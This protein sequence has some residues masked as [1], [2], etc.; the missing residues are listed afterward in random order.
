MKVGRNKPC[1]CGSGLKYKKCCNGQ[2]KPSPMGSNFW[3]H[4]ETLR[5]Q[6]SARERIRQSQ[7]GLGR[8]IVAAEVQGRRI[9]AVRNKLHFSEKWK[10][11]PDFLLAYLRESLGR[12]WG[13]T[14]NSKESDR[15]HPIITWLAE[16]SAFQKSQQKVEGTG[17]YEAKLN[18]LAV[19]LFGLAYNLY[20]LDHNADLQARLLSRLR[21]T[22]QFQGAYYELLI[23]GALIRAGFELALEDEADRSTKHCEF[24][25]RSK[26]SKQHYSV[27]VKMKAM[28]GVLGI[29][30]QGSKDPKPHSSLVKQLNQSFKKPSQSTRLIFI[31][32][33]TPLKLDGMGLPAWKNDVSARIDKYENA[34]LPDGE[35]A[36]L[37]V[38]NLPFH[39]HLFDAPSMAVL[40]V[41]LGIS[42]FNR[43]GSRRFTDE[44]LLRKKHAD[45]YAICESIAKAYV[46]PTTFDGSLPS[47]ALGRSRGRV[48]IGNT[49]D[50]DGIVGTVT[51]AT[52]SEAEK[53]TY[54]A[55]QEK[56][57]KSSIL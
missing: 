38:T 53:V 9:V 52:V 55:V 51:S 43:P 42:D 34:E 10:T 32:L 22:D 41:G 30:E 4:L 54:V 36:Y 37:F 46:I 50:F 24:S 39:Y 26:A 33:N 47:E 31:D 1:P 40:P 20:L 45:A 57:G 16:F 6:D 15:K 44:Y 12:E 11:F 13:L 7:Q 8:P 49:Y 21:H 27:E 5:Q 35:S 17:L 25:A 3:E 19:C 18:G 23:A 14:E 48:L 29:G 2:D 28:A 56:N